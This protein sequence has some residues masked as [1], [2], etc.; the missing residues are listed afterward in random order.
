MER[1]TEVDVMRGIA[2]LCVMLA[3]A[4]IINVS[5][6]LPFEIPIFWFISGYLI[7]QSDS[8]YTSSR[9]NIM[10]RRSR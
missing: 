2:M 4:A 7:C 10:V 3:H 8:I 9:M 5:L 6:I 1:K